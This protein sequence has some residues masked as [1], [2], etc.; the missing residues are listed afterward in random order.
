MQL[1]K[2][3]CGA[4]IGKQAFGTASSERGLPHDRLDAG[5][6]GRALQVFDAIHTLPAVEEEAQWAVQWVN[7]ECSVAERI[8]AF[9]C[10]EGTLFSG[11]LFS[12]YF[13]AIY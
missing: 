1:R 12:G 10:V 5:V 4:I 13:C 3:G 6:G 2:E 11:T 9:A 7:G 8:V